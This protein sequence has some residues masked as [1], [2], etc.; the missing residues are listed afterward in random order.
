[1]AVFDLFF[2]VRKPF[3]IF[4]LYFCILKHRGWLIEN[5]KISFNLPFHVEIF[6]VFFLFNMI[7]T[8]V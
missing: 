1:M 4:I 5:M 6:T 8:V 2:I 3:S 7:F